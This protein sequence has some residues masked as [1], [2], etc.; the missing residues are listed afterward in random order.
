[1]RALRLSAPAPVET[2]P[3]V[4]TK[5]SL[6]EPGAGQIR[7]RVK[8]C[9]VCHTDRHVVEGELPHPRLPVTPGHQVAGVVDVVGPAVTRFAAGDRVGVPWLHSA[10]GVCEHCQRGQ[11]N[12]CEQ[13]MFTGYTVDGGYA[14]YLLAHADFAVPL[15]EGFSDIEVAPLL[16]AGIVGYRSLRLAD[17]QPGERLGLYGFGGSGHI[18]IQVARHWD[19]EVYVFTRSADHQRH[20]A[21]LGAAWTGTA[22]DEPPAKLDRAI[23]FAPA[24]WL[25]P[26]ALGHLRPGGA[27]CI[28]AIHMSNIP[29]MPYRLLWEERTIRSV[30]NA[31]RR[32][33]QEFLPLAAAIPV[34][35][36]TQAFALSDANVALQKLKNSEIKGSAV[37]VNE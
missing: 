16:C 33:A 10:C 32:D 17:L 26:L 3:L 14:E 11:E 20:A 1:M 8:A 27:L 24:G 13:A 25:V 5:L 34:R 7:V 21:D 30:A 23:I 12:L 9:G 31:T 15:P 2:S 18:C 36:D 22:Q 4:T 29:E 19:C 6:P 37:L 28:N 35:T